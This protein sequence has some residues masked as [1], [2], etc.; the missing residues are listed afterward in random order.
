MTDQK[1]LEIQ[2]IVQRHP[3]PE[4]LV[5]INQIGLNGSLRISNRDRKIVVYFDRGEI[6]FAVSNLREHR[7]FSMLLEQERVTKQDLARIDDYVNDFRLS[8]S[9]VRSGLLTPDESDELFH[10]QISTILTSAFGWSTGTWVFSPLARLREDLRQKV[11]LRIA[12]FKYSKELTEFQIQSRFKSLGESFTLNTG[13]KEVSVA[14]SPEEAFVLSRI[15]TDPFTIEQIQTLSGLDTNELMP[16]LYRLWLGGFIFRENWNKAFS[17]EMVSRF[18]AAKIA[19]SRSALSVEEEERKREE[20]ERKAA[21]EEA[22]KRLEAEA[23][24][25]EADQRR[26]RER[27]ERDGDFEEKDISIEEYLNLVANAPTFYEMF[28]IKPDAAPGTVKRAYFSYARRFHPDVLNKTVE[29]ERHKMIQQAFTEIARAYETLRHEDS[30]KIYDLKLSK[31]IEALKNQ[32]GASISSLTKEDV[33]EQDR[34]RTAREAFDRATI[35]LDNGRSEEAAHLFARAVQMEESNA[36]Y[37]AWYG[38]AL[39]K[40]KKTRHKAEAELREA[41][42]LAPRETRFRLMLVELYV[43]IGLSVRARNEIGRILE[44]DP[45]NSEAQ[46]LLKDLG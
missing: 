38:I 2:G 22:R 6:S 18:R 45:G 30:R 42:R 40:E 19:L 46:A 31:V 11:D 29:P 37:H 34:A 25:R 23:K 44:I 3:I 5:E 17:R 33:A 9:L 43:E 4:L 35:F 15:G 12:L 13:A 21:E 24:Q 39:S 14:F 41:L 28:G 27:R 36:E 7:L 26:V 10:S 8:H 16:I 1:K 32:D 20:E